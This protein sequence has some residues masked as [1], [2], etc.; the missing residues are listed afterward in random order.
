MS[1]NPKFCPEMNKTGRWFVAVMTGNGPDSHVGDFSAEAEARQWIMT[2]SKD[3]PHPVRM[4]SD[5]ATF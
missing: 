5:L 2:K 4:T 3:W 1:E